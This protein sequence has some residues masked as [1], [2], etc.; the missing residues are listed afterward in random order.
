[1]LTDRALGSFP[2]KADDTVFRSRKRKNIAGSRPVPEKTRALLSAEEYIFIKRKARCLCSL[3]HKVFNLLHRPMQGK[4]E[5][6]TAEFF[7]LPVRSLPSVH[8]RR[9]AK[10]WKS[11][12]IQDDDLVKTA[13]SQKERRVPMKREILRQR[14]HEDGC[15]TTVEKVTQTPEDGFV[16]GKEFRTFS[17]S[18]DKFGMFSSGKFKGHR[19]QI[20]WRTNDPKIV[21]AAFCLSFLL[22]A[23]LMVGG[24]ILCLLFVKDPGTKQELCLIFAGMLLYSR[25]LEFKEEKATGHGTPYA[26]PR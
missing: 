24:F 21:R 12:L 22:V 19:V 20:T 15:C 1:M 11:A 8:G 14:Q 2:G 3:Q 10:P 4:A 16:S 6:K 26:I 17:G 23:L 18:R 25:S 9:A 7:Q 5:W 13:Y